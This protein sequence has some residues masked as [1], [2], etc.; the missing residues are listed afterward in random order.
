MARKAVPTAVTETEVFPT[1]LRLL[2]EKAG[3]NQ[4][5]L[6]AHLGVTRQAVS[7]YCTGQ[8]SPDWKA[9]AKIAEY[10]QVSADYLLGISD[11]Q[12]VDATLQAACEYT[13][14]SED[15]AKLMHTQ[16]CSADL[17]KRFRRI[18][19]MNYAIEKRSLFWGLV[20]SVAEILSAASASELIE[21]ETKSTIYSLNV[22]MD[23]WTDD[24]KLDMHYRAID[25]YSDAIAECESAKKDLKY[26]LFDASESLTNLF[27]EEIKT[28]TAFI[29][30]A[31]EQYEEQ[32]SMHSDLLQEFIDSLPESE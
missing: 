21:D 17:Q 3:T 20:D 5:D 28:V 15:S 26:L 12:S 16:N 9:I 14:L 1:R 4:G 31:E 30:N 19:A 32:R 24:I 6:A 10:F 25:G 2:M 8:S 7:H 23:C 27:S 11:V 18:E 29:Q 13:G 22:G